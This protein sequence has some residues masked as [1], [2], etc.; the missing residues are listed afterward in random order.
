[1]IHTLHTFIIIYAIIECYYVEGM[2]APLKNPDQDT[3]MQHVQDLDPQ[4]TM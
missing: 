4:D 1:M 3:S 2:H